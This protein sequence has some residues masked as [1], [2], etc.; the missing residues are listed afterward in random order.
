[1]A[2]LLGKETDMTSRRHK[3]KKVGAF[4]VAVVITLVL[5]ACAGD[6]KGASQ[7]TTKLA[8]RTTG[9]A[10]TGP[11]ETR[12]AETGPAET[13]PAETGPAET[14]P[15]F[16]IAPRTRRAL[17]GLPPS[18]AVPSTPEESRIVLAMWGPH[19]GW[20]YLYADG[21]VIW[22]QD[23]GAIF[24]LRLSPAGVDLFRSAPVSLKQEVFDQILY[25]CPGVACVSPLPANAW[26]DAKIRAWVPSK[27]AICYLG[28]RD[29]IE[30]SRVAGLLPGPAQALLGGKERTYH[31]DPASP[32]VECSEVTTEQARGLDE[33]LDDAGFEGNA[34]AGYRFVGPDGD[35]VQI[36][37]QPILP[38]GRW[39]AWDTSE[40]RRQ[41]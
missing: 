10:V 33:I 20:V 21:R 27:Y 38:H 19:N 39:V 14:G 30:P 26:E 4:A 1:V 37:F 22:S 6:E 3:H 36:G 13:G 9:P 35:R 16:T 24:E 29:Y 7:G 11:A 5:G 2:E 12:P 41:E 40:A 8:N 15:K 18:G 32:P 28:P 17:V 34:E 25:Q 23:G 31:A